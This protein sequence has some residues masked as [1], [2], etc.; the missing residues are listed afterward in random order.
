LENNS[1]NPASPI[2]TPTVLLYPESIDARLHQLKQNQF[3][4]VYARESGWLL[5]EGT[6]EQLNYNMQRRYAANGA[7]QDREKV[8]TQPTIRMLNNQTFSGDPADNLYPYDVRIETYSSEPLDA[9][10]CK[11]AI[12]ICT[13]CRTSHEHQSGYECSFN[14]GSW[15]CSEQCFDQ[16]MHAQVCSSF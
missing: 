13:T 10:S 2:G 14:C 1:A 9:S 8:P 15:F 16:R 4:K 12:A 11:F 3:V 5:A 6:L 7:K